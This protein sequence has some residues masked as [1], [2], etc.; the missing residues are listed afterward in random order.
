[1][2]AD[3]QLP[4]QLGFESRVFC[5]GKS[6]AA[7]IDRDEHDVDASLG[8]GRGGDARRTDGQ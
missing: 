7:R 4:N 3:G 5:G 8:V 1:M 2:V 6:E